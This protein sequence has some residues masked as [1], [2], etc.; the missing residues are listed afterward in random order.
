MAEKRICKALKAGGGRCSARAQEGSE[1]CWNHDPGRAEERKTNASAGGRTRSR[2]SPDE[3]E[4]IKQE[5][6]AVAT[7]VLRDE[8]DK[9]T[10]AVLGQLYNVQLRCIEMQR[11]LNRVVELEE[12]VAELRAKLEEVKAARRDAWGA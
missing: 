4:R 10:G 2:R 9:G 5:I 12:S 11:K 8:V 7:I 1:W 3:L 6:R